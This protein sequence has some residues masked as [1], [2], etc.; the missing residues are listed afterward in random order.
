MLKLVQV[1]NPAGCYLLKE[2]Y[3]QEDTDIIFVVVKNAHPNKESH[4]TIAKKI[5]KKV[6]KLFPGRAVDCT[7]ESK[8]AMPGHWHVI[9]EQEQFDQECEE[10]LHK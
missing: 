8:T 9:S 4:H 7:V 6:R 2:Y 1:S 10:G 3:M 5:G